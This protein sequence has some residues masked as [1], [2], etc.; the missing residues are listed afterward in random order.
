MSR[1]DEYMQVFDNLFISLKQSI[2]KQALNQ[3]QYII[4]LSG[5]VFHN[6]SVIGNYGLQLYKELITNLTKIG[7]TI[8]FHGN[9]DKNQNDTE[10][11]SLVSC[12]VDIDKLM[13]LNHTQ[14]F[15]I[16]NIGFS[17]VNI[18]DTLDPQRTCGRIEELP[19]FP[20][21]QE[22]VDY[23]VALFHGTFAH[24]KLYNG[25]EVLDTTTGHRPYPLEWIK[26]F[27]FAILGDIHLRQCHK[28]NDTLWGYSGSLL[29][30]DIGED[31]INH[32][33]IIW[34]LHEKT[35]Q[36]VDVYNHYGIIKVKEHNE[37]LLTF[38]QN[39]WTSLEELIKK[40][41]EL[42]PKQLDVRL[43]S[44][45]DMRKLSLLLSKNRIHHN[46]TNRI[47]DK[48]LS[49]NM[50]DNND[51]IDVSVDT[52]T[53]LEYFH[54]ELTESQY[55]I[56]ANIAQNHENLLLN[57]ADYPKELHDDCHKRNKDISTGIQTCIKSKDTQSDRKQFYIKYIEWENLYCY[58]GKN[59]IDFQDTANSTFLI[60]GNNGTGKSAIYDI[61]VLAIWGDITLEK[62]NTLSRGIV[63]SKCDKGHTIIDIELEG[64]V[65]RISKTFNTVNNK[66][67]I[68]KKHNTLYKYLSDNTITQLYV[69]NAC[70]QEIIRLFGTLTE[71]LTS[72]MITQNL[73]ANILDMDYSKCI[74]LIDRVSN[75]EYINNF[76]LLFKTSMNKYKDFKKIVESKKQVYENYTKHISN[77]SYDDINTNLIKT[78][79][80]ELE[81]HK[82]ILIDE[83]NS[84][85]VPLDESILSVDYNS[86][87][88][89]LGTVVIKDDEHKSS[90]KETCNDI[91]R[92]LRHVPVD[93]QEQLKQSFTKELESKYLEYKCVGEFRKPCEYSFIES[94]ENILNKY[95]NPPQLDA[96]YVQYT[97]DQLNELIMK[98]PDI[99]AQLK[100]LQTYKPV[101]VEKPTFTMDD[102]IGK[103][104]SL[105]M[106]I[107]YCQNHP[108]RVVKNKNK[109]HMQL[110]YNDYILLSKQNDD[111]MNDIK[112]KKNIME[113]LERN[114]NQ[115]YQE[116]SS[117][118]S[119]TNTSEPTSEKPNEPFVVLSD[120]DIDRLHGDLDKYQNILES[121]YDESDKISVY[122][123][124]LHNLQ[125][126]Y[127]LLNT[128]DEFKYNPRC[129]FCCQRPWVH[130]IHELS[131]TIKDLEKKIEEAYN[132]LYDDAEHDY[133]EVYDKCEQIQKQLEHNHNVNEWIVYMNYKNK[134]DSLNGI[135]N[136][137]NELLESI[138]NLEMNTEII[139]D[140]LDLFHKD[141]WSVYEKYKCVVAYNEYDKWL[142][143]YNALYEEFSSLRQIKK[144]LF[145]Q[146]DI[147]PRKKNLED[148][149][150]QYDQWSEYKSLEKIVYAHDLDLHESSL[151]IYEKYKEYEYKK[152]I[153][154]LVRRKVE[155][156]GLIEGIDTKIKDLNN[157]LSS[158]TTYESIYRANEENHVLLTK[159]LESVDNMI[160][161]MSI[162]IDK[163]KD[164]K[165]YLYDSHILKN[166]VH[167][168]NKIIKELCHTTTKQ[169]ELDYILSEVK[170]SIHIHWLIKND[171]NASE[172]QIISVHQASGFQRFAISTALRMTLFNNK[173][174]SQL[175][176]DEG[177]TA[178]DKLNL[179]IVPT[180]LMRL[181]NIY[182]SVII[183][184]HIDIIQDSIENRV[185]IQY[186]P[187]TKSSQMQYGTCQ[188]PAT[189]RK[190]KNTISVM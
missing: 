19:P 86:A 152:G 164:Y 39:Q 184:S 170:D 167:N 139:Q 62:Q 52:N 178:C 63:H 55:N 169:F 181:L 115:V 21:I 101:T 78:E 11:P 174:C 96:K 158:H 190:Q 185:A 106:L 141:S 175:F 6:K 22:H 153:Q 40:N 120:D 28:Y 109:E 87:V 43:Y 159:S 65:Y 114:V 189:Q 179:S 129:K 128:Q 67:L 135:L 154:P 47:K 117:I 118:S 53:I 66:N 54:R 144:F 130:R 186:N 165:K 95:N 30:Q 77:T 44:D 162:I 136:T 127:T 73:D 134:C 3:N 125:K 150:K 110:T 180:F 137:K 2:K 156:Q 16:N 146:R 173:S 71:F 163:F 140:K 36:E 102:V 4:I 12:T 92:I 58:E 105:D 94:E 51:A 187:S 42:F 183:V 155:I 14:S 8:I 35:V 38:H 121:Y 177:F 126:E 122:E 103:N 74:A 148:L 32:G 69:D 41:K 176:I 151:K 182:N 111:T 90:I 113:N 80:N 98:I 104:Q 168:A 29:Q 23:K 100:E 48:E 124:E 26:D 112:N 89:D 166:I 133:L 131:K 161:V 61:L 76:Y 24:V 18:D 59:W 143:N 145:Y 108:K 81:R 34:D 46:I 147:V 15:T 188:K 171:M 37:T 97:E 45:I 17:Y 50:H 7:R 64:I 107:E 25:R 60:S 85:T 91:K 138:K 56:F 88:A 79:L 72:S 142:Q 75:I 119:F 9:H 160:E 149:K 172:K 33:Y 116:L 49:T 27:D 20:T 68:H 99:E 10:Q 5:D 93:K 13:I 83:N 57:I 157:Q 1:F 31:I 70:N 123:N 84:L 132:K 82:K